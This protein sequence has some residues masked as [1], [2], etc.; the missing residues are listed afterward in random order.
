MIGF[1]LGLT[2]KARHLAGAGGDPPTAAA[3]R[4]II[5][6]Y[7]PGNDNGQL[8]SGSAGTETQTDTYVNESGVEVSAVKAVLTGWAAALNAAD[9]VC[10]W[11]RAPA[12]YRAPPGQCRDNRA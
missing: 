3:W 1:D 7:G 4:N 11:A 2:L 8:S 9:L 5:A 10:P 12:P 6:A